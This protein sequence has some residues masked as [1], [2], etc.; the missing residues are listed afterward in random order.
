MRPMMLAWRRASDI[1]SCLDMAS[2]I[3]CPIMPPASRLPIEW[4]P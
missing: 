3:A 2:S 1:V 4:M